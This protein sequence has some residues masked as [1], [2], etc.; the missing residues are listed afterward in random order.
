MR[1][2]YFI[3][4]VLLSVTV[5]SQTSSKIYQ[6]F[7]KEVD[8]IKISIE[9]PTTYELV[10]DPNDKYKINTVFLVS[11]KQTSYLSKNLI[12]VSQKSI[13][14]TF[15]DEMISEMMSDKNKSIQIF[16][17]MERSN[18][19]I[20]LDN[21]SFRSIVVNGVK[22]Y[23]INF[24]NILEKNISLFTFHRRKM[25]L[26]YFTYYDLKEGEME[27]FDEILNSLVFK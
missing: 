8:G 5:N 27:E 15:T 4:I 25:F 16:K 6:T 1:K 17:G 18:S 2:I 23:K 12:K 24:T 21:D 9:T 7:S 3:L 26:V 10:D 13:P 22:F 20:K 19:G 11:N 14:Q